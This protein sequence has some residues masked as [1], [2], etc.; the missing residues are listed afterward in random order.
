M[1]RR[2][3]EQWDWE[4]REELLSSV[5]SRKGSGGHRVPGAQWDLGARGRGCSGCLWPCSCGG[6]QE[7]PT[8]R[9]RA[10]GSTRQYT[11]PQLLS[12]S[13]TS[14]QHKYLSVREMGWCKAGT[15]SS[16]GGQSG[17]RKDEEG[18]RFP[19]GETEN[20]RPTSPHKEQM[21]W[22]TKNGC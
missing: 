16:L 3:Y 5:W 12:H 4:H 9:C 7:V 15:I 22:Y 6:M 8:Q 10:G 1:S 11:S 18:L 13:L 14:W 20:G 17:V 19:G 21:F 2:I